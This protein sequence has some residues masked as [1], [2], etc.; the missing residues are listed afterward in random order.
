VEVRDGRL[1]VNGGLIKEH[2]PVAVGDLCVGKGR[3]LDG[4][5]ATLGDNR[6]VASALAFHLIVTKAD[7]PGKVVVTFGN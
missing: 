3:L 5:F 1:Y 2:H 6:A 4:D 7:I